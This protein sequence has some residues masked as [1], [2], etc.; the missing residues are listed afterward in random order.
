M[1][2]LII[3]SLKSRKTFSLL[4]ILATAIILLTLPISLLTLQKNQAQ[5]EENITENARGSYDILVR[6][7]DSRNNIEK[8]YGVVQENYLNYGKG[9][10]S[11]DD[12]KDIKSEEEIDVAAPVAAIGY[13]TGITKSYSLPMPEQSIRSTAKFYTSNGL[14]KFQIGDPRIEMMLKRSKPVNNDNFERLASK[15]SPFGGP[16]PP[17]FIL[18]STYHFLVGIN[19]DSETKLTGFSF[20]D[21]S[22]DSLSKRQKNMYNRGFDNSPIVRVMKL[23][24]PDVPIT[25]ESKT[26]F[27]NISPS[28]TNEIITKFGLGQYE[29]LLEA[30]NVDEQKYNE[31]FQYVYNYPAK[32]TREY[33]LNF[34]DKLDPFDS[35]RL[36]VNKQGDIVKNTGSSRYNYGRLTMYYT[37]SNINYEIDEENKTL[38]V[39]KINNENNSSIFRTQIGTYENI[40]SYRKITENGKPFGMYES[41][42]YFLATVGSYKIGSKENQLA[43]SPLGIYSLTPTVLETNGKKVHE[44]I[45]PGSFV[46]APAHGVTTIESAQVIKGKKPIDAIRV[47]VAGIESYTE[48]AANKIKRVAENI[49]NQGFEVD[50]VAG[51]SRQQMKVDVEG[52]GTVLEPWTTLGAAAN[53]VKGWN[54]TSIILA[55]AFAIVTLVYLLSRLLFANVEKQGEAL[56]LSQL[57]WRKKHIKQKMATEF[58]LLSLIGLTFSMIIFFGLQKIYEL[59][60]FIYLIQTALF[61]AMLIFILLG[62]KTKF[63]TKLVKKKRS[64]KKSNGRL[65]ISNLKY[66]RKYIQLPFVQLMIVSALSTFVYLAVQATIDQTDL[67]TLGQY[68][69]V[70]SGSFQMLIIIGAYLLALFTMF[71]GLTTLFN[72]RKIELTTFQTIGWAHRHIY[73]LLLSEIAM[74]TGGAIFMGAILSTGIYVLLYGFQLSIIWIILFSIIGF[75]LMALV[76]SSVVIWVMLKKKLKLS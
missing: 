18:P 42:P 46:P 39:S 40:P 59:T 67:T 56:L 74:W 47:R 62:M 8:K 9:G 5:I 55:V 20:K 68:I 2:A 10:I 69:N 70:Q 13:F 45:Y 23:K 65:I 41:P 72:I 73:K 27:L 58:S 16:G 7:D 26:D 25:V 48:A 35:I 57:G 66:Y 51:A 54:G 63:S 71:E 36:M 15:N 61:V 4:F 19:P 64:N 14:N 30:R 75:Y 50:V 53:I 3:K 49:A 32:R 44:T 17:M 34:S 38:S 76:L 33:E 31:M 11:I 52:V 22:D 24:D 29:F 6:P 21:L 1:L 12:W 60:S 37:T 28:Q 43:A